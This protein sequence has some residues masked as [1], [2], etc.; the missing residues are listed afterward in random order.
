MSYQEYPKVMR[1]PQTRP[2]VLAKWDYT[3]KDPRK[4]VQGSPAKFP[5]VIVSNRDQEEQY[6]AKGY[7]PGGVSDPDAYRMQITGNA[8]PTE[9]FVEFPKYLYRV[10]DGLLEDTL[11]ESAEQERGLEGVWYSSPSAAERATKGEEEKES[12]P[13]PKRVLKPRA[14][15]VSDPVS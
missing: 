8:P 10:K 12:T 3:E 15:R 11:V 9:K 6:A 7:V 2:A 4:Q 13:A 14:R 5:D 1:H